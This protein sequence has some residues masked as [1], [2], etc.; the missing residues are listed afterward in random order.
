MR[1]SRLRSLTGLNLRPPQARAR[2][3]RACRRHFHCRPGAC[4]RAALFLWCG[5]SIPNRFPPSSPDH[6]VQSTTVR[7]SSEN[8]AITDL[9]SFL[10]SLNFQIIS[11]FQLFSVAGITLVRST[12]GGRSAQ[13]SLRGKLQ[14]KARIEKPGGEFQCALNFFRDEVLWTV[15]GLR[16]RIRRHGVPSAFQTEVRG[17]NQP[18]NCF[19]KWLMMSA[20][21]G[22][23]PHLGW[24]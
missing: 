15:C 10:A 7:K 21:I 1:R 12:S 14:A 20:L 16:I 2:L 6:R 24:K 9:S 11:K 22:I 13:L 3:K 5:A 4:L 8:L 18:G 23:Y 17:V 19:R